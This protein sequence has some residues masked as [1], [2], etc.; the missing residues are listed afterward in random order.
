MKFS[1]L[2]MTSEKKSEA[3]IQG[4]CN[5][6]Y[7]NCC[8]NKWVKIFFLC[9]AISLFWYTLKHVF[10]LVL[11][12]GGGL[13]VVLLIHSIIRCSVFFL[14]LKHPMMAMER[15]KVNEKLLSGMA[16]KCNQS[17]FDYFSVHIYI[18]LRYHNF[19]PK[20]AGIWTNQC[21]AV[22]MPVGCLG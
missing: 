1:N 11:A 10:I 5:H 19:C 8:R 3:F 4:I 16:L 12:A 18:V 2:N 21:S 6:R 9:F 13:I 14:F 15:R 17:W 7:R 20:K 22:E